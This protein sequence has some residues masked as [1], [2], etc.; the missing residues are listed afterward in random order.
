M[1]FRSV[2]YHFISG[3]TSK[4][5]GTEVGITRPTP[6]FSACYGQPFLVRHPMVYAQQL[7]EQM[8]KF[9]CNAWLINTGWVGGVYGVGHR[10]SIKNTRAIIDAI[11]SGELAETDTL[12]M[13]IFG[14]RVP[15]ECSGVPSDVLKPWLS[16]SSEDA[17][18]E[19]AKM[20]GSK[21]VQNF[22]K[23]A[24]D[25]TAEVLAAGPQL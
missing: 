19:E 17:Y 18:W 7:K 5:A 6:E 21:F 23:Y 14:L 20:L 3:Y 2:M 9:A 4:V 11:H 25:V 16:W 1:L 22:E 8:E 10:M 12:Q 13:D 24:Q 15:V